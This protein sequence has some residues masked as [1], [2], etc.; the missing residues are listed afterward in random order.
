MS[1]AENLSEIRAEIA[2]ACEKA[3]RDAGEV[4]LMAVSKTHPPQALAEAYRAGQTLFG[5][6]KVQ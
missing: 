2:A 6:N 4:K 1:I 5:E 3:G